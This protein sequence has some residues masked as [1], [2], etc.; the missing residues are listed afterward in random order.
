M[1]KK[2]F[3]LLF[4]SIY[5]SWILLSSGCSSSADEPSTKQAIKVMKKATR[6]FR[7]K[8]AENGGYLWRYKTDFTMRQGEEVAARI[9][10]ACGRN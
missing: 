1:N 3:A 7:D 10:P 6:Y 5:L 8:V 4:Y 2:I 9:T